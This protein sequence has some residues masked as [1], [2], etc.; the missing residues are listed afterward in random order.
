MLDIPFL[1]VGL[2]L[3]GILFVLTIIL[4]I[5]FRKVV[6][7]NMV[8][9]VQ[10]SSKTRPYGTNLNG[11]NVYYR[12]PSWI[13]KFGVTVIE[14]PVS[15]FNRGLKNY[16]AYDKD[17]VPF[18]V[19]V[20]AF[21]RIADTARAAQRVASMADL[22]EQLDLIVQGAVRKVLAS[23]VI[24]KIMLERAQFGSLFTNEVTEQLAE[25]G[26]E[27]VKAME[28]M[29]IRDSSHDSRVIANIM[30]KKK[31]HIEMES[32]REVAENMRA[33]EMA[34]ITARREV[35]IQRQ[36]AEQAVGERTAEKEK[37]VGIAQQKAAQE[38]KTEEANT[39]AKEMAVVKVGQVQQAEIDRDAAIVAADQQRE[40]AI[41]EA[42]GKLEAAKRE[43]EGVRVNGVARG[44]AEQAILMAPV[45]AQIALA[46]KIASLPEYQE[47][48]R[49]IE[50]IG[51]YRTVGS[52]QAKAL[53]SADVKVISNAGKPG[54]GMTNVMDLFTASGGTN[55]AS[56]VE[57]FAQSP[58]GKSIV[59]KL[60]SPA[61]ANVTDAPAEL[62]PAEEG[63]RGSKK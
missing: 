41:R 34:E 62:Q 23:D 22:N 12:W 8:H 36:Q 7:T 38:V 4:A 35:D 49:A 40:V 53:Q 25:W 13:P 2:T 50:A 61:S 59:G 46:E 56:A 31:S 19:D 24:D 43:A 42:D 63:G 18:M 20:T 52:E 10:S 37:V 32:R 26:V 30:A 29:D 45:N 15:N 28:L 51:A 54:E 14:L 33:A 6:S 21:F 58:L 17:R 5:L 1:S 57:A 39:K 9:I 27:P 55:L 16:E 3:V 44:E 47:Y 11:G 48:L 60:T